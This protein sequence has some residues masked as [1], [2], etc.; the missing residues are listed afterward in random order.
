MQPHSFPIR[1]CNL[2]PCED[3]DYS[4]IICHFPTR[5]IDW[6]FAFY[7][8]HPDELSWILSWGQLFHCSLDP[9]P[10][11]F[12]LSSAAKLTPG[13][14][15]LL[16][17]GTSVSLAYQH[18]WLRTLFLMLPTASS[19]YSYNFEGFCCRSHSK[20]TFV[21]LKPLLGKPPLNQ[22]AKSTAQ[23]SLIDISE[24]F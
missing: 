19:A 23:V 17:T 1:S 3:G 4:K 15:I 24:A 14:P 16:S 18:A 9:A 2:I 5:R 6:P 20:P 10:S 21:P 11:S 12:L 13:F 8:A 22:A 7:L